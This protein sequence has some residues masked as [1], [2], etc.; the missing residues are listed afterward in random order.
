MPTPRPTSRATFSLGAHWALPPRS[1]KMFQN[2]R[3][4]RARIAGTQRHAAMAGRQ[5]HGLISAEQQSSG[6]THSHIPLRKN[7]RG[8]IFYLTGALPPVCLCLPGIFCGGRAI[9]RTSHAPRIVFWRSG[10]NEAVIPD[11]SRPFLSPNRKRGKSNDL[12]SLVLW[13]FVRRGAPQIPW[14]VN[15]PGSYQWPK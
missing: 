14:H 7:A 5:G 12:P 3:G 6:S 2:L 13:A 15:N 1:G 4:G 8:G 10:Q 9:P 11:Y